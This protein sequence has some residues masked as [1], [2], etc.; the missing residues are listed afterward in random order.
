MDKEYE[1][2]WQMGPYPKIVVAA[3]LGFCPLV[4]GCLT[5]VAI[6][7]SYYS[8]IYDKYPLSYAISIFMLVMLGA[9]WCYL[10][11]WAFISM[12][13]AQYRFTKEGLF[14]K[15]PLSKGSVI[16]WEEFQ[17][18]CV[19]YA[20]YTTRGERRANTVLCCV[21]KGEKKNMRRRWKTD[22]IFHYRSVICIDYQPALL[23]GLKDVYPGE[24]VDLRDTPEYRLR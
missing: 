16:P 2:L 13:L 17:Q 11:G 10:M 20:A 15:F 21:K 24:V 18:V 1:S 3:M 9:F 6:W 8:Y 14:A 19:C 12:G 22:S 7:V 4:G 5:V 23:E